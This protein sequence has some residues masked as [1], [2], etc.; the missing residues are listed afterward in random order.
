MRKNEDISIS[1]Y[2]DE[3]LK[4]FTN[5]RNRVFDVVSVEKGKIMDKNEIEKKGIIGY[6][7]EMNGLVRELLSEE[8]IENEYSY[9][10]KV[11]KKLVIVIP[12]WI[13]LHTDYMK[14]SFR[15]V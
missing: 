6:F 10:A 1:F 9:E 14:V 12:E 15:K 13:E 11:N 2:I 3:S 7:I 5:V 8:N 4:F